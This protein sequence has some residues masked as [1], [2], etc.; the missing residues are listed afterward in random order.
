[1]NIA[2]LAG[3][4]DGEGCITIY[5][6]KISEC[7]DDHFAYRIVV[8]IGM[9]HKPLVKMLHKEFGG[10]YGEK[11]PRDLTR[12]PYAVWGVRGQRCI[13]LL[14]K[15]LPYLVAKKAEAEFAIKFWEDKFV[16]P[17]GG[18]MKGFSGPDREALKAK[19][20]W[21]RQTLKEMKKYSYGSFWDSGEVGGSPDR[22]IP[23]QAGEQSPGVRNE[24]GPDAKAKMCSELGGN[25]ETAAEKSA[26]LR[27]VSKC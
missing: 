19:R 8:Q 5:R 16:H 17:H 6:H 27:L 11:K 20:E 4:I 9:V 1:M 15:C 21:Y 2:Y 12:R 26:G 18:R 13:D 3:L 7:R 14:H 22:T 23:N 25:V 24:H 10:S